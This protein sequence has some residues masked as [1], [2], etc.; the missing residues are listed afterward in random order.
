MDE[1]EGEFEAAA[2]TSAA[3]ATSPD[4]EPETPP[5]DVEPDLMDDLRGQ[6]EDLE[7]DTETEVDVG[8]GFTLDVAGLA[9]WQLFFLSVLMFLDIAII[10]LMF[11][12]MLGRMVL[13][14][15]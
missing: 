15:F 1:D 14:V 3:P 6:F 9:P 13:P 8:G 10:G 7:D 12:L 5:P 2:E 11:M 4:L